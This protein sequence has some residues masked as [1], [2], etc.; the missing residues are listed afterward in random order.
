MS[1]GFRM[2]PRSS[3]SPFPLLRLLADGVFHSGV[4]LAAAIGC[5]PAA[6]RSRVRALESH[7][8]G[9]TQVRGRGYRLAAPVDLIEPDEL[10]RALAGAPFTIEL[11]DECESTN[12]LLVARARGASGFDAM[13]ANVAVCEHQAAG[14]GRRGARWH[15]VPGGS[16]AFSL[17]WRFE[18]GAGDL[19]GLSLAVAVAVVRALERLGVGGVRLKWPN[20]L[21]LD[22]HAG[23][24]AKLGGILIELAGDASGPSAAVIGIGL[25][26]RVPETLRAAVD[27][28]V[29][30]IAQTGVLLS[31]TRLLAA[32]LIEL[33][34]VLEVFGR[35]G[36]AAFRGE[37]MRHHAFQGRQVALRIAERAV[38]EG[39]AVGVADD[40]ALQ[41]RSAH[42]IEQFHSGE[43]SLRPA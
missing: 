32:L 19:S 34:R 23:G 42:G 26:L 22:T 11:L 27:Y 40:G 15:S 36:F 20:D 8:V 43:L 21:L 30:D 14:R 2:S 9:V 25:N 18:R 13:H 6:L 24:R 3:L 1:P 37:W 7:G 10:Q 41:L 4:E 39:E 33:G 5:T 35:E 28:P 31:R 12:T 17:L 29:A 38:A 16:L